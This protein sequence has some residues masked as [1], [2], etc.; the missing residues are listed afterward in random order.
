M[1]TEDILLY[2]EDNDDILDGALIISDELV[3][4][5]YADKDVVGD[6]ISQTILL[7]GSR[8]SLYRKGKKM[9]SYDSWTDTFW[10]SWE[11]NN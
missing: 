10:F 7:T 2:L 11:A 3:G 9:Y 1:K 8:E 5:V 6:G 4:V